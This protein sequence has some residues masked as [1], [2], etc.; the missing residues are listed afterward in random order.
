MRW[1]LIPFS[2]LLPLSAYAC[3][4]LQAFYQYEDDVESQIALESALAPLMSECLRSPEFFALYG[5]ALMETGKLS[6]AL[7]M[8]ERALLLDPDNGSALID[9]AQALY[10]RGQLFSALDLN[11]QLSQRQGLPANVETL[12]AEREERW[13]SDTRGYAAQLDVLA[14]YDNNLNG[15]PD[16][17]QITLTLSGE[18]VILTLNPEFQ[19]ISG[20]YLNLRLGGQF[21]QMAADHQHQVTG[22][23]RSRTSEDA[24]SDLI[25]ASAHYNYLL[26]QRDNA[27]QFGAGMNHLFFGG[28]ALYT[29]IDT[30]VRYQTLTAN[31]CTRR[32]ELAGQYQLYKDQSS[33]NSL[34]SKLSAGLDCP[35]QTMGVSSLLGAEMGVVHS[36]A[37]ND[38]RPG[39]DRLGWQFNL[40][41]QF[42][43][44]KGTL[45]S[46]FSHTAL[47]DQKGYSDLLDDGAQRWVK[48]SFVLLQYRQILRPNV[49]FMLNIYHQN[50]H[51]NIELFDSV[52]STLELGV[53]ASF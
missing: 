38:G 16:P 22:E 18:P 34:E 17:N 53:S 44:L 14:G 9:Y 26:P 40:A 20:P 25:Q 47:D 46:Q 8:L 12:V 24:A 43:I 37:I 33:L 6:V 10:L 19:A 4:D 5:A 41:W 49:A 50:Q 42:P 29:A 35:I 2:F 15:A 52:D 32:Y 21:Q 31:S 45:T 27:W 48:R 51:S 11:R 30:N 13:R 1:S 39:G 28:S 23:I 3:P 7:E 36:A